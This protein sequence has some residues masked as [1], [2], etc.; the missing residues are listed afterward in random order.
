MFPCLDKC[1]SY[2][3]KSAWALYDKPSA[4]NM[5]KHSVCAGK[6]YTIV[7]QF[8]SDGIQSDG[9]DLWCN[10]C[11]VSIAIDEKHQ[12]HP[13]EQ[14]IKSRKHFK[15]KEVKSDKTVV[16]QKLIGEAL[17]SSNSRSR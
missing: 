5:S 7:K 9:S 13:V 16:S 17:A 15:N 11:D 2:F 10:V 12:R 3:L 8:K 14:H 4:L 1:I 6:V